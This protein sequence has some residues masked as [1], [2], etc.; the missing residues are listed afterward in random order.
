[1]GATAATASG[2]GCVRFFKT[3]ALDTMLVEK[4]NTLIALYYE[5]SLIYKGVH[6]NG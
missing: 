1:M 2:G 6:I 5:F 3:C 4:D